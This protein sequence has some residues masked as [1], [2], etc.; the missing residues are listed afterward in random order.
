MFKSIE[1]RPNKVYSFLIEG[2]DDEITGVFVA[3]G[4]EWILVWENQNDF[5]LDGLRFVHKTKIEEIIREEDEIF[6]D[7]VF[8]KKYPSSIKTNR[9][10]LDNSYLLFKQ[11]NEEEDLLHYDLDN[12]EEIFLGMIGT[13]EKDALK[14]KTLTSQAQWS[15]F[16][17][18]P[19]SEIS[20]IAIQNDYLRSLKL[21]L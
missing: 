6:K 5:L 4:K 3:E 18:C 12:D 17:M 8:S 20:T 16:I 13:L 10:N 7:K 2:W 9:Y 15:E 19:F 11:I 1:M 21:M 14:L